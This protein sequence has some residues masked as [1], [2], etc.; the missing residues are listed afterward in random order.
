MCLVELR[1]K[2]VPH[3]MQTDGEIGFGTLL[4]YCVRLVL[5]P[6]RILPI[7]SALLCD[8]Y[9]FSSDSEI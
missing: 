7:H 9:Q 8:H 6:K 4:H 5:R 2:R 3:V 1:K